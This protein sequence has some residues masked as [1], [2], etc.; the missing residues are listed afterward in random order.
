[1]NTT[2]INL[3]NI[4]SEIH[5]PTVVAIEGNICSGKSVYA[6][7]LSDSINATILSVDD[8]YIPHTD[9]TDEQMAKP[10]GNIDF[11]SLYKTIKSLLISKHASFNKYDCHTRQSSPMT[12][13][14][15]GNVII[16]EGVYSAHT[17]LLPLID[18]IVFMPIDKQTQLKR[19]K[20]RNPDN[21]DDFI[22]TWLL[23]E[24]EYYFSCNIE[25]LADYIIIA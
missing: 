6:R 1:M 4:L 7:Q 9:R 8:F 16:V 24:E 5:K 13:L 14:L 21:Y 17:K 20:L 22:N 19:L 23:R 18:I 2:K 11:D 12:V 10:G 15:N 25:Q 3:S